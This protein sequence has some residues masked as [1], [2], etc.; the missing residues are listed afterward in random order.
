MKSKCTSYLFTCL[1]ILITI[2]SCGE[3][4]EEEA[5]PYLSEQ[6]RSLNG[7]KIINPAITDGSDNKTF[8][9]SSY[10]L[11]PS[12]RLLLRLES[13]AQEG[14][15]VILDD[16]HRME[17]SLRPSSYPDGVILEDELELCP[18]TKNWMML[19]TWNSAHPFPGGTGS[20]QSP[21][22]D[23]TQSD[24]LTPTKVGDELVFDVTNW[25]QYYSQSRG[26]NFGWILKSHVVWEVYGDAN[27]IHA[28]KLKWT[29]TI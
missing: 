15:G 7:V 6:T 12:S 5:D 20:W 3:I 23:Y 27:M 14:Q 16:T 8:T 9:Q 19:A 25:F 21:G 1:L 28:P 24:C 4:F 17:F 22:G 2:T 13:L 18:L 26:V 11:G 29:K 10:E